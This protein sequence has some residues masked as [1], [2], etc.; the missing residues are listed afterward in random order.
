M[1]RNKILGWNAEKKT[2]FSWRFSFEKGIDLEYFPQDKI[3]MISTLQLSSV[4]AD[5]I[6][7]CLAIQLKPIRTLL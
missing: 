5:Y 2:P 1:F 3:T 4:S 6:I 7:D